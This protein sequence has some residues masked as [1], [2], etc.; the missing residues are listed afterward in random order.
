VIRNVTVQGR[1][2]HSF[3][4]YLFDIDGT[5]LNCSDAVHYFAFCD[6]LKTI[7]GQALT[8]DG[9]TAHGNTDVGI[10]RDA[11]TVGGVPETQWRPRLPE[12]REAMCRFVHAHKHDIDANA[13]PYVSEVLQHLR[14][15]GATLGIATG[16]L[17]EI[18]KL[19][20]QHA[21]VLDYFTVGGW[22]DEYEY[23]SDVF[24]GAVSLMHGATSGDASICVL[25]DTPADILAAHS[26]DLP[27]IAV[28]TGVHSF[29]EL[30]S[31][32]PDLCLRSL[33]D[34]WTA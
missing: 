22:S 32:E 5:L 25:G 19:K 14:S 3:D 21:G 27:V 15:K 8:L 29:E 16:N 10:L 33:A 20:L 4:G 13:L 26:N 23:R 17:Q 31:H 12:I 1:A 9:V 28:S 30:M 2:W 18:G 34:L 6:S 11:F 24:R 7:S